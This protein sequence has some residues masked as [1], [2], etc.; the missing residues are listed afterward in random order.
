MEGRT[1]PSPPLHLAASVLAFM[2]I[3]DTPRALASQVVLVVKNLSAMQETPETQVQFL[4]GADPLEEEMATHSS[5]LACKILC[6]EES[7]GLQSMGSRRAGH[8]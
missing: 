8:D 2:N 7:D 4:G 3:S 1:C 5:I 6:S